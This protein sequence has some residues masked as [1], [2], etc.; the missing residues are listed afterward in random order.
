[1]FLIIDH[2]SKTNIIGPNHLF[3]QT[4]NELRKDADYMFDYFSGFDK[5]TTNQKTFMFFRDDYKRMDVNNN[6]PFI[7][8]EPDT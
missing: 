5:K 7:Y 2:I 6:V 8:R 4:C 3:N 1:M